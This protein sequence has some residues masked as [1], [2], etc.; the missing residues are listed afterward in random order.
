MRLVCAVGGITSEGVYW[1]YEDDPI[2]NLS[3]S[4]PLTPEGVLYGL[5]TGISTVLDRDNPRFHVL[6][7]K[8]GN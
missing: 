5:A 3:S 1:W 7:A 6:L 8:Y 2:T 4:G